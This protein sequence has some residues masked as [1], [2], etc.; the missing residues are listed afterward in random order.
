MRVNLDVLDAE[1]QETPPVVDETLRPE[2]DAN[3]TQGLGN[4]KRRHT[5]RIRGRRSRFSSHV[6][7]GYPHPAYCLRRRVRDNTVHIDYYL[8]LQIRE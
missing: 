5:Y 6:L 4:A 2:L 1:G 8:G 7:A 3:W